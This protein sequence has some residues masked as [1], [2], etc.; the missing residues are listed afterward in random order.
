MPT[1]GFDEQSVNR[2]VRAVKRIEQ[3]RLDN[4][5]GPLG[6][7][8]DYPIPLFTAKLTAA[9][10][11]FGSAACVI[12]GA[13][14]ASTA[15]EASLGTSEVAY[16]WLGTAG[17]SGDP[18]YLFR[19]YGSERLYFINGA[20][21]S[22]QLMSILTPNGT[23][24]PAMTIVFRSTDG[25]VAAGME[26]SVFLSYINSSLVPGYSTAVTRQYFVRTSTGAFWDSPSTC[27]T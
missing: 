12:W 6:Q 2:V 23:D 3:R 19:Q 24:T 22:S 9:C 20:P 4:A 16:D 21:P 14:Q 26:S 10:T 27:T 17:S 13:T 11:Q 18:I 7:N 15:A 25:Q 8:L 5:N 1:F